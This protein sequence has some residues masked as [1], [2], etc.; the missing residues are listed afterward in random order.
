MTFVYAHGGG[1]GGG[2]FG[3]GGGGGDGGGGDG[4]GNGDGDGGGGLGRGEGGG[5]GGGRGGGCGRNIGLFWQ[6]S[7]HSSTSS[8][9]TSH[10]AMHPA[11]VV[12]WPSPMQLILAR[13]PQSLTSVP[14]LQREV[15]EPG[16]PSSH[17]PSSW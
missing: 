5:G 2:G 4:G 1:S 3:G 14:L 6:L 15:T 7:V 10:N 9:F 11:S 8:E 17:W 12:H 16:P 13:F